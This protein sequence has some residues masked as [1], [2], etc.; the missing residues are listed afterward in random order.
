[1]RKRN[2]ESKITSESKI[3]REEKG[4]RERIKKVTKTEMVSESKGDVGGEK[5]IRNKF[6]KRKGKKLGNSESEKKIINK[7]EEVRV[8]RSKNDGPNA[9]EPLKK[10]EVTNALRGSRS[11]GKLSVQRNNQ[12]EIKNDSGGILRGNKSNINTSPTTKNDASKKRQTTTGTATTTTTKTTT[13]TTTTTNR[14]NQRNTTTNT[15]NN[16]GNKVVSTTSTTSKRTITTKEGGKPEVKTTRERV[17]STKKETKEEKTNQKSN[18]RSLIAQK[19]TP[20]LRGNSPSQIK[21]SNQ[22]GDKKRAHSS[23]SQNLEI[24]G[25]NIARKVIIDTGKHPKKEY[26]LNVRKHD[27][28]QRHNKIRF[29]YNND[30]NATKTLHTD[31]NHNIKVVKNVTKDLPTVDILPEG[32]KIFHRYNYNY[33]PNITNLSKIS[34]DQTGKSPKKQ[35]V[36]SPRKNNVIKTERKPLKMTYQNYISENPNTNTNN[37][38]NTTTTKGL[39][40]IPI[41]KKEE[42]I[43]NNRLRSKVDNTTTQSKLLKLLL[44]L[45]Q[46]L[47]LLE[48]III[49]IIKRIT[50]RIRVPLKPL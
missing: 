23:F 46:R 12:E 8:T 26:V 6:K 36:V 39:R 47:L 5:S 48:E 25:N 41:P 33:N 15:N 45:R 16:D 38:N 49:L 14:R 3:T 30:P 42:K 31:F 10:I 21:K 11:V 34:I 2:N 24:T 13:T 18:Q 17:R 7:K 32:T 4:G 1:M 22:D 19:S 9:K 35:V 28:I 40:V 50:R 44:P 20:A 43:S 29:V 27:V 37:N